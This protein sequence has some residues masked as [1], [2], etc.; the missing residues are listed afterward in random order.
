MEGFNSQKEFGEIERK[1][2]SIEIKKFGTDEIIG[3]LTYVKESDPVPHYYIESLNVDPPIEQGKGFASQLMA[4]MEKI[5]QESSIPIVLF[6]AIIRHPRQNPGSIGM[7]G[8]HRGW[9][10]MFPDNMRLRDYFIYGTHDDE[11][12][13]RFAKKYEGR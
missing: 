4:E 5:S 3:E 12:L 13:A 11:L 7:Y 6:D 9:I 8:K 1:T 10:E 2:N